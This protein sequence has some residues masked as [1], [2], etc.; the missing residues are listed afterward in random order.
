MRDEH[1]E[2]VELAIVLREREPVIIPR[3]LSA[4][5]RSGYVIAIT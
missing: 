1:P 3:G 4:L 2:Q 5:G